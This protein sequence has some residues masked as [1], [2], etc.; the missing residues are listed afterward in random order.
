M[1]VDEDSKDGMYHALCDNDMSQ[2]VRVV[3]TAERTGERA[4]SNGDAR[5]STSAEGN[6]VD[7]E[8]RPASSDVSGPA[9]LTSAAVDGADGIRR[10]SVPY[11]DQWLA[12][13]VHGGARSWPKFT[14]CFNN[15]A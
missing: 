1:R 7:G 13:R 9:G 11:R 4:S 14:S 8:V 10:R 2:S 6:N 15:H 12:L 5:H 3:T